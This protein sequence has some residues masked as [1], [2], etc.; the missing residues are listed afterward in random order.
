MK[1]A[2]LITCLAPGPLKS[3]VDDYRIGRNN[4]ATKA[5]ELTIY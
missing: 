1:P 2:V 5:L 3:D 4:G